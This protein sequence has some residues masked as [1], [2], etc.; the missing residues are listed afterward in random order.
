MFQK[1]ILLFI[2]GIIIDLLAT[3]YTRSVAD[4]KLWSAIL[5]S[6]LITVTNFLL[7]TVIIKESATNG[8]YNILA[9]TGGNTSAPLS[10]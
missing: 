5:L 1:I 2:V 3:R 9:Y 6:G 4:K 10:R 8:L 7:L